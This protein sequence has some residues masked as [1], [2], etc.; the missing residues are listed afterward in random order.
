MQ[1]RYFVELRVGP[2]QGGGVREFQFDTPLLAELLCALFRRTQHQLRRVDA[3]DKSLAGFFG[4]F[5]HQS[6]RAESDFQNG[7]R[8]L[9]IEPVQR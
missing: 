2:G 9:H 7:I 1:R 3:A 6:P 8:L 4:K 5:S